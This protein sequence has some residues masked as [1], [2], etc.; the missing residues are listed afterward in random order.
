MS[1][2]VLPSKL[3]TTMCL[4]EWNLEKGGSVDAAKPAMT[5]SCL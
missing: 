2:L 3:S 4:K 5:Y 1:L